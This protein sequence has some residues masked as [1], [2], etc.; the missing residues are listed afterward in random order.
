MNCICSHQV[1][2]KIDLESKGRYA[3]VQEDDYLE[4]LSAEMKVINEDDEQKKNEFILLAS[5]YVG[6]LVKCPNCERLI[7]FPPHGDAVEFYKKDNDPR[8]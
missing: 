2:G 1:V 8:Q 6:S 7:L 5:D 3:V 4:F